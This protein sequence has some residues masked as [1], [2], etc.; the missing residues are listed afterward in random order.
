MRRVAPVPLLALFIETL[1][2]ELYSMNRAIAYDEVVQQFP[3][4]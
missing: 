3:E 1:T 2:V 4:E